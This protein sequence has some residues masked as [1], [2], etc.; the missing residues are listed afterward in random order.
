MIVFFVACRFKM[1]D[2]KLAGRFNT[3]WFSGLLNHSRM[4]IRASAGESVANPATRR[5][6]SER[7]MPHHPAS[8]AVLGPQSPTTAYPR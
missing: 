5:S 4:K 8:G 7:L 1:A 3:S 2:R 6:S